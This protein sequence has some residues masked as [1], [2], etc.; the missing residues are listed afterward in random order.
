LA[1]HDTYTV[2]SAIHD[3]TVK[4]RP[5]DNE[6]ISKIEEMIKKNVDLEAILR[7]I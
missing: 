3:M 2:A 4:I 5:R 1:R 7:G 6:K